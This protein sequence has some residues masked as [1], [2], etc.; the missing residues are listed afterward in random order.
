[1]RE[2]MKIYQKKSFF[3]IFS[4]AK[5]LVRI[6]IEETL[7]GG[8][9]MS[10]NKKFKS[11]VFSFIFSKPDV[12]REL[13]CALEGITLKP[14]VPVVINT[15]EDILFM[16][17]INDISFEIG[18]KLVV[19][20]EHQSTINPNMA[21]R[22]LMYIGR[23]YEK[24]LDDEKIYSSTKISI[25][26]PEFFV[27]YNG[28][29]PFPDEKIVKLSELFESTES[30]GIPK[31]EYL[32]LELEVRVI[33]I[34]KG[35]NEEMAKKCQTLHQYS[36]FI[37]KVREYQERGLTLGEAVKNTVPYCKK[38]DIL[39]ELMDKHAKEIMSMLTTEWN[40]DTAKRVWQDEARE[41]G[42]SQGREEIARNALEEGASVDFV[43][44]ITG[45]SLDAIERLRR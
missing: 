42:L 11:S 37:A 7:F 22:L 8:K 17:M 43:Q 23:I 44:K 16:D 26:K 4:Q 34:N 31:D 29:T 6:H 20:I 3:F 10:V 28:L 25:P 40:W 15:L 18:G 38:H 9:N 2:K 41:E 1:M 12:L 33:N 5:P 35:K 21:L 45:L 14:D 24:I 27:L 13:Y 30:L 39:K 32:A 19:L 36:A